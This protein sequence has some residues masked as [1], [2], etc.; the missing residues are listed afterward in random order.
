MQKMEVVCLGTC[1]SDSPIIFAKDSSSMGSII[2]DPVEKLIPVPRILT[3][4][5]LTNDNIS[6]I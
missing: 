1:R 2:G 6:L 4:K 5:S 3:G